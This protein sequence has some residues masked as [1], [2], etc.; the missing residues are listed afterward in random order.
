MS[1][2]RSLQGKIGAYRLH[3]THDPKVT[4]LKAR[5]AFL[6]SFYEGIPDDLPEAERERR[7]LAARKAHFARL[8]YRSAIARSTKKA[9]TGADSVDASEDGDALPSTATTS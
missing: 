2:L 9:P 7:A 6:A 4:T 8:A 3:A 5:T 1:A